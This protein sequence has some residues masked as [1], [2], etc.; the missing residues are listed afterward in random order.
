MDL[1]CSRAARRLGIIVV[2]AASV[3]S[4]QGCVS[5]VTPPHQIDV[6][7]EVIQ[8]ATRFRKEYTLAAG[9]AVEVIVRRTPEASRTVTIRPDGMVTLPLI[10]EVRAAG[11]TPMELKSTLTERFASRLVDPEVTII[12]VQVRLPVVYV[13]GDVTGNAAIVPLR[14]AP[15]AIQAITHAGGFRRSAAN[16]ETT[17]IRLNE[18]GYLQAIRIRGEGSGQA[19]SFIALRKTLLQADDII[20]VPESYRSQVARALDDF[21]NRPLAGVSAILSTYA[22]FR[23]VEELDQIN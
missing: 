20:F 2:A 21:L 13:V 23:V 9:D 5:P 4:L 15:T 16:G 12:P 3:L 8:S 14:D 6:V 1:L 19:S 18:E 10:D 22:N 17:I 7:P 11:L